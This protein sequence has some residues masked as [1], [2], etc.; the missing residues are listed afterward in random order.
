[1]TTTEDWTRPRE[2]S[3]VDIAFP[4]RA[5]EVMPPREEC[6][7]ALKALGPEEERKWRNFQRTWFMSGL[8]ETFQVAL[9]TIDGEK[10]DGN[11]AF[12]HLKVIQGSF[13]P[14][15][16]HKEAAVAYLASLWFE[17]L[18]WEGFEIAEDDEEAEASTPSP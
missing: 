18:S 10:V 9:K 14:K 17:D 4:A 8:P 11:L 1:M 16:E 5:L 6:E 15:H 3:D 2:V 12:R 7:A 13:A